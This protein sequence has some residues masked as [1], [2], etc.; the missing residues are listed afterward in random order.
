MDKRTEQLL[1]DPVFPL[2]IKMSAPNT[3]AFLINAFVVLVEFWFIGQLGLIPLAAITL[4]FPAIML[5]QQMAFGALGGAVSSSI[6]RSLGA[7]NIDKAEKLLWHSLYISFLGALV[8]FL[9][10]LFFGEWLLITLGGS[11]DLLQESLAY[12]LVYL[13][14]GLVV[15]LSGSLTAALR[16][17]GDMQFPAKLTVVCA[18]IQV[19]LSSGFILGWF[20]FP[21]LGL[22]GSAWSMIITS[23]FMAVAC[24]IKLL[25]A[26]SPIKLKIQKITFEK[27]L[28]EDIFSVALPASLSPIFT[29]GT[30]LV[31]TGLIG[32]FGTSA[33]AG[34]GI[35]SRVEFLLIPIVF[36]IGT[37][38]TT[39]VGT[40]I[41][42]NNIDRA[43]RIGMIGATSAGLLSG[44]IGLILALTPDI[45]IRVFTADQETLMVTKQY[46][47][48]L[49]VC[50]LFQ[51]FGLSLYFA[52]Q[53]A[54][55]M[56]WPIVI[57]ALR[58]VVFTVAALVSVYW[59]S[60]GI[61]GI[62]YSS[63]GAMILFGVLMVVALKKG[64][65]RK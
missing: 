56:K 3:V 7:N 37:A 14:G 8:F 23:S 39:M 6:S 40:N 29:V 12:C 59:L 17:M 21:K 49:G 46:I 1:R 16:G 44:V 32:Q 27:N 4:A 35:G 52:S 55:A 41:G 13:S 20:G 31:L 24:V 26:K 64:A 65:W 19:F 45:W 10:F 2:L 62:F 34:Y 5:T 54:N 50:Y 61:A 48:I 22:V 33:I 63:G 58:F 57:T 28:F 38:M 36:S 53:G 9:V 11:S 15:W 30:V 25:S 43:E 60:T 18:G 51:G 42:A 47:Q